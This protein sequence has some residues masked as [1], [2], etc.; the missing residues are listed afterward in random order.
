M[1]NKTNVLVFP[2]GAENGIEIHT[3]LKDIVNIEL[4]GASSKD[5]H[6]RFIFQKYIGNLPYIT[7]EIFITSFN[8]ILDKYSID[9]IIPTHDD[10]S[11]FLVMNEKEIKAKLAVPGVEQA[12]ICRS[13]KLTY[14]LFQDEDFCPKVY[15]SISSIMYYPV[16]AKPDQGQGGQGACII[17][18]ETMI[19][20]L[21]NI[22]KFVITEYLPGVELTVDCFT[23]R[24]GNLRFVSPRQ[25]NR[26]LSGISVNSST[27]KLSEEVESIAN[28]INSKI[29]MRGLWYFQ[30]KKDQSDK[31]KLLEIS[32]RT[33]GT[34]NLY[35]G[36]GV[37][38]PL[39]TLYDLA[40]YDIE[41]LVNDYF[42]EVDR[43][44]FNRYKSDIIYN[45]IYIDFDDTITK[46]GFVNSFVI[47][48]LYN[49]KSNKKSIKL[50]T[51]HE[52]DIYNSLNSLSI[53][54]G[55]FA[56]IIHIKS[57]DEKYKYIKECSEVIFIDNSYQE[58]A[59]VKKKL[60]I[61]VFDIDAIATLIDWKE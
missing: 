8:A 53:H 21:R 35:R 7:D 49:S 19:S 3:A 15:T 23:D 42:L 40:G 30:I 25:R 54:P 12:K 18:D 36:L 38:F 50:I 9:I 20:E 52:S 45:T 55:L 10:I 16:F 11:L 14:L 43:S 44:L 28:K 6:G 26:I 46:K 41:I 27:V 13:K 33:A 2:C 1:L 57:D 59:M 34:M 51:K 61:P 48:F 17:S 58:R 39:L 60:N 5:D 47:M 32:I 24:H 37:N 29:K 31:Y 56:E 22:D 4:F